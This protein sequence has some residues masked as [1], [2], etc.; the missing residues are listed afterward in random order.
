MINS[1]LVVLGL[2]LKQAG[3][4]QNQNVGTGSNQLGSGFFLNL[5][6]DHD[7]DILT[8]LIEHLADLGD[9]FDGC[10]DEGLTSEAGVNSHDADH[11]QEVHHVTQ[12]SNVGSGVDCNTS[13][14][15]Q[16][17]DQLQGT[18]GVNEGFQ[19]GV[20]I[21]APALAKTSMY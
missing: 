16:R 15:T 20:M 6:V 11:I 19:M 13:L 7:V 4:T 12:G 3:E 21:S 10:G 5:A 2:E 9:L 8:S 18:N 14:L 17:A 1:H